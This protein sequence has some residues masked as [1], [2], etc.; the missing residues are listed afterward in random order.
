MLESKMQSQ[1][2]KAC[3]KQ[4]AK[5]GPREE[6]AMEAVLMK[7]NG[8]DSFLYPHSREIIF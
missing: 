7:S 3:W 6:Q 4:K 2:G 1:V 8:K 5:Q